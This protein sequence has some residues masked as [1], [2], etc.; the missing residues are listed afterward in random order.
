MDAAGA[1]TG[2]LMLVL[3]AVVLSLLL[4]VWVTVGENEDGSRRRINPALYEVGV[5]VLGVGCLV[6]GLLPL[7]LMFYGRVSLDATA[8]ALTGLL[9]A[10]LVLLRVD[11]RLLAARS[12]MRKTPALQSDVLQFCFLR[13]G[14]VDIQR[15]V[16]VPTRVGIT[17]DYTLCRYAVGDEEATTAH[18]LYSQPPEG[19][20]QRKC[21]V[22]CH[23]PMK[24]EMVWQDDGSR[25][26]SRYYNDGR[27]RFWQDAKGMDLEWPRGVWRSAEDSRTLTPPR[28][29]YQRQFWWG[30]VRDPALHPGNVVHLTKFDR[31]HPPLRWWG[32][33]TRA[34][35]VVATPSRMYVERDDSAVAA[36]VLAVDLVVAGDLVLHFFGDYLRSLVQDPHFYKSLD[37]TAATCNQ[38]FEEV[39]L[40][41]QWG[42]IS[43]ASANFGT[44]KGF[45]ECTRGQRYGMVFFLLTEASGNFAVKREALGLGGDLVTLLN[46]EEAATE[47]PTSRA[48]SGVAAEPPEQGKIEQKIYDTIHAWLGAWKAREVPCRAPIHVEAAR[49]VQ[50]MVAVAEKTVTAAVTEAACVAK[51]ASEAAE[52]LSPATEETSQAV[53]AAQEVSTAA[54]EVVRKTQALRLAAERAKMAAEKA[55]PAPDPPA[56]T[57]PTPPGAA[58]RR[59]LGRVFASVR[60]RL[61]A[62]EVIDAPPAQPLLPEVVTNY[63]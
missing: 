46:D 12:R 58:A 34:A 40:A 41:T 22:V 20:S 44:P 3:L 36:L 25:L 18:H 39:G 21:F 5:W 11:V 10:V 29:A 2:E 4:T 37:T 16:S 57:T 28:V 15:V 30:K 59:H 49:R 17:D 60:A 24:N 43:A 50:A 9:P 47:T 61:V 63:G 33:L 1:P 6:C 62:W 14:A 38:F 42:P 56:S 54:E 8:T 31:N 35:H 32:S 45:R 7:G 51:E 55:Y 13:L 52:A 53:L 26:A 27:N 19:P 23:M 48:S